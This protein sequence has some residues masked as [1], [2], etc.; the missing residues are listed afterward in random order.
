[1]LMHVF[2]KLTYT[3]TY[4]HIYRHRTIFAKLHC[5]ESLILLIFIWS[6]FRHWVRL[7]YIYR[8]VKSLSNDGAAAADAARASSNPAVV[9]ELQK[10]LEHAQRML[11][12]ADVTAERKTGQPSVTQPVLYSITE[13]PLISLSHIISV[14]NYMHFL[15][16]LLFYYWYF[17]CFFWHTTYV[18]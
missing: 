17:Y 16:I 12:Q 1:M 4:I 18:L 10:K 15:L 3:R 8:Q 5:L 14:Y 11:Q 7:Y 9:A 2:C 13:F 6:L